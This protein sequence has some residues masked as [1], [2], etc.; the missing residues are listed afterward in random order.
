MHEEEPQEIWYQKR[1]FKLALI[2]VLP[3]IALGLYF[4]TTWFAMR[5]PHTDP[6]PP[7]EEVLE[8]SRV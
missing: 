6:P 2:F 4:L 1:F 3:A 8:N 5:K 7:G